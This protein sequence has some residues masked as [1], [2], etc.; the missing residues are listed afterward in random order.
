MA[1]GGFIIAATYLFYLFYLA[2]FNYHPDD[3]FGFGRAVPYAI[4]VAVTTS[5]TITFPRV[6]FRVVSTGR[7]CRDQF[8]V[9]VGP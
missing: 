7:R 6:P 1:F 9:V 4:I 8:V 2:A 5:T 3:G